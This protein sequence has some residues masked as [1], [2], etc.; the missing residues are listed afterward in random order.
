MQSPVG[1][2]ARS[3]IADSQGDAHVLTGLLLFLPLLP[4]LHQR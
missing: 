1:V 2:K 3:N 4:L